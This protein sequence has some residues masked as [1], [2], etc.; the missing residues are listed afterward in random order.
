MVEPR[1]SSAF[2]RHSRDSSP[3]PSCCCFKSPSRAAATAAGPRPPLAPPAESDGDHSPGPAADRVRRSVLPARS[4]WV[5]GGEGSAGGL[6][7]APE[8]RGPPLGPLL[9]AAG[10]H[11]RFAALGAMLA[12][13]VTLL[14]AASGGGT[15]CTCGTARDRGQFTG[16]WGGWWLVETEH[17]QCLCGPRGHSFHPTPSRAQLPRPTHTA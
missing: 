1:S 16:S 9:R 8:G 17:S 6:G 12:G 14:A 4:S 11:V 13:A 10:G 15:A 2:G 7:A 5:R 3:F